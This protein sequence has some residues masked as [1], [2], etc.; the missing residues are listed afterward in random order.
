MEQ[1]FNVKLISKDLLS[2][3]EAL[4]F[5]EKIEL[6]EGFQRKELL[7]YEGDEFLDEVAWKEKE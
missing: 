4:A 5:F 1:L 6:P 2:K 7:A 3:D